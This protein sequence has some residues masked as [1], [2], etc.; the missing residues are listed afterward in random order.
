M[1]QLTGFVT[2]PTT[3][4]FGSYIQLDYVP[5]DAVFTAA[6]THIITDGRF[7][8]NIP[9]LPSKSWLT[10]PAVESTRPWEVTQQDTKHDDRFTASASGFLRGTDAF[11]IRELNRMKKRFFCVILTRMDGKRIVIAD[12]VFPAKFEFSMDGGG[13]GMHRSRVKFKFVGKNN[14]GFAEM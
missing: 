4:A 3:A 12:P 2:A 13:E 1:E 9:L 7:I 10:M 5:I 11:H 14:Y 8:G 6:M